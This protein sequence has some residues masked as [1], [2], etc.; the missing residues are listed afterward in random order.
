MPGRQIVEVASIAVDKF[1]TS[2]NRASG[3]LSGTCELESYDS[4]VDAETER[5]WG[6]DERWRVE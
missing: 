5:G 1:A 6:Q 2:A 4:R 3:I